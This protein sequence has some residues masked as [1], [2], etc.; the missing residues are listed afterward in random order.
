V[1]AGNAPGDMLRIL[2]ADD[3]DGVRKRVIETLTSRE[4]FEVCGEAGT[5]KEAVRLA[6][7][8]KPDL[9]VLDITMPEMN[10]LDAARH[11][12]DVVPEALILILS[13]HKSR[14]LMEE[15]RKV[16]VRGYVTKGEAVQKLVEAVDA[17]LHDRSFFP[18]DF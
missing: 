6:Q 16:G 5:G 9:I 3:Q 7:E 8:L 15:A 13:V 18:E 14:Q 12:R 17:V 2:V 11:I 1:G 4:G 10:G